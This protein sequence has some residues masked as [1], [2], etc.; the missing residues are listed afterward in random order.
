MKTTGM[1]YSSWRQGPTRPR[2]TQ[3]RARSLSEI[4][5]IGR[6]HFLRRWY[7]ALVSIVKD[8]AAHFLY[9]LCCLG[10]MFT[11]HFR[12][13]TSCMPN[14]GVSISKTRPCAE[15]RDWSTLF[16]PM[17]LPQPIAAPRGVLV[18]HKATELIKGYARK[19]IH[20]L[21]TGNASMHIKTERK[22][23]YVTVSM[24]TSSKKAPP[25]RKLAN[26]CSSAMRGSLA[27]Y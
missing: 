6:W 22:E 25:S 19:L 24:N 1:H 7:S 14:S 21:F 18:M 23:N 13:Y 27:I 10:T 11:M 16:A 4:L 9:D 3:R 2:W 20:F 26:V 17:H 15:L 8:S 12:K 5:R